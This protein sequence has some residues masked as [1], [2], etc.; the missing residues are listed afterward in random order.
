MEIAHLICFS[1]IKVYLY[2][3]TFAMVTGDSPPGAPIVN[4]CEAKGMFGGIGLQI[5]HLGKASIV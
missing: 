1:F 5:M 3:T 2:Y 4:P